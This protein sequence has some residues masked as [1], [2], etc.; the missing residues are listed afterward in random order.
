MKFPQRVLKK[1]AARNSIRRTPVRK[2]DPKDGYASQTQ[3]NVNPNVSTPSNETTLQSEIDKHNRIL[4]QHTPEPVKVY[5]ALA[6]PAPAPASLKGKF[7]Y[8]F[9]PRPIQ[10]L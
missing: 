2:T 10:C 5:T 1:P 6:S 7:F 9:S 4:I 3:L 8:T